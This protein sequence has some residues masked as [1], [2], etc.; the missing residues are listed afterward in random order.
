[1][2]R[3][4]VHFPIFIFLLLFCFC[5]G[6]CDKIIKD[7]DIK[8]RA[9]DSVVDLAEICFEKQQYEQA[10]KYY[11][12]SKAFICNDQPEKHIYTL[13]KLA[14]IYRIN[15]DY[16]ES[17]ATATEAFNYFEACKDSVYKVYIYNCLGINFQEKED[18]NN[19]LWYYQKA[20]QSANTETDKLII[21][22]N[23]AVVYLEKKDYKKAAEELEP[24]L[25]N[26]VLRQNAVNYAKVSDN[27]GF[28]YFNLNK[29][30][31]YIYLSQSLHIRDSLKNDFESIPS[32]IHFSTF[33][34]AS[35]PKLSLEFAKKALNAATR[36]NNPEDKLEAL[37][38]LIKNSD[39]VQLKKYYNLY[40][41]L[42]DEIIKKKQNARNAFAKVKY[43]SKKAI[44]AKEKIKRLTITIGII[45]VLGTILIFVYLRFQNRRKL[46]RLVYDTETRIAKKIHDELANDI[47]QTMSYV[48]TQDLQH[49]EKREILLD[50]L[51]NIYTRTRNISQQNSEIST[52]M[53]FHKS[54][55]DLLN[56]FNSDKVSVIINNSQA[57]DWNKLKKES[58]IALYRVL[59]E[60]MVNM[61]KH[62][63]CS[64]V[65]ISFTPKGRKVEVR[66]SDN[67]QGIKW[68]AVSK[69]GLQNVENRIHTIRGTVIFES[70]STKGFRVTITIPY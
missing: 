27:L 44:E 50:N 23:I 21:K 54:L 35:N 36:V 28:A 57:I 9:Y 42:N 40:F 30:E 12:D 38:L 15:G 68:Q 7:Q 2:L 1:M 59:Q 14:E 29:P 64:L 25:S 70:E 56:S 61:K 8:K 46:K 58:K 4:K 45:S 33:F 19:A 47:F 34:R 52:D 13:G 17:E 11:T 5:L 41:T 32:F 55:L 22:N 62:S 63:Q 16:L 26:T 24:L 39:G 66:Y 48:E 10:F 60:L 43:D 69:K 3:K 37:D 6:S 20:F 67:G 53:A 18:F 49:P 31:A 51:D 65:I